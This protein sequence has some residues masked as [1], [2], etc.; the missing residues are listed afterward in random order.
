MSDLS[1]KTHTSNEVAPTSA[2]SSWN[3]IW[4]R[5]TLWAKRA[6]IVASTCGF[7]LTT[8]YFIRMRWLPIDNFAAI[9]G[10]AALVFS[11]TVVLLI[12]LAIS[13]G[14]PGW[15]F[16]ITVDP[17]NDC[18]AG[19]FLS[20]S[21]ERASRGVLP[22]RV[23]AWSAFHVAA[24]V[25]LIFSYFLPKYFSIYG[26]V[27]YVQVPLVAALVTAMLM[28]ARDYPLPAAHMDGLGKPVKAS[29]QKALLPRLAISCMVAI[30]SAVPMLI[31]LEL[32]GSSE[33]GSATG[34]LE[35]LASTIFIALFCAFTNMMTVS[36]Q[37][38]SRS[39][40]LQHTISHVFILLMAVA[41]AITS[42]G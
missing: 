35:V 31:F 41:A 38:H 37:L 17:K 3:E 2:P 20:A 11:L 10:I 13:A 19:W 25:L 34:K 26:K 28:Y 22:G 4:E 12:S 33:Y 32:L 9:G 6:A 14:L 23:M 36:H 29:R 7:G 30:A 24:P 18:T 15:V 16:F 21:P 40:G 27:G 1:E 42:L 39:R 8:I 5:G